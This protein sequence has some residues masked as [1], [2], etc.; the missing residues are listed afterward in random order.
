MYVWIDYFRSDQ[1]GQRL[2][3]LIDQ[4]VIVT[5]DVILTELIPFLKL[6]KQSKLI[7]LMMMLEC[8]DLNL[9]WAEIRQFQEKCL[10]KEMKLI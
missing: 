4:N 7:K 6:R 9:Q 5:N 8:L 10:K 2:D 3:Q 1:G